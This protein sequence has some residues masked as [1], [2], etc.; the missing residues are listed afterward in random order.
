MNRDHIKNGIRM[1][2][3]NICRCSCHKKR[4]EG[5]LITLEDPVYCCRMSGENYI[6]EDGTI[7]WISFGKVMERYPYEP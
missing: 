3:N 6:N 4:L 5:R 2:K 7:D 1:N